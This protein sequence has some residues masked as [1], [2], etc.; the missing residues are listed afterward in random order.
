MLWLVGKE[1]LLLIRYS[2][3]FINGKAS[4][5]SRVSW[6]DNKWWWFGGMFQAGACNYSCVGIQKRERKREVC[7]E[8]LK[9]I[10]YLSNSLLLPIPSLSP[11]V[12]LWYSAY[13][14]KRWTS[15]CAQ[16]TLEWDER[17]WKYRKSWHLLKDT[18]LDCDCLRSRAERYRTK[19]NKETTTICGVLAPFI[20]VFQP[21]TT[22]STSSPPR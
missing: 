12:I 9:F 16:V 21:A 11:F 4:W 10:N 2:S 13:L 18:Q 7:C 1:C 15:R 6:L 14:L 8:N 5:G 3:E 19:S 17:L 22:K 20:S